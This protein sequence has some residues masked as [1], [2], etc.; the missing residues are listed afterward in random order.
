M[1][2]HY[3]PCV[4][5]SGILILIT[6]FY[7]DIMANLFAVLLIIVFI[8]LV[9]GLIKPSLFETKSN[10][11][12]SRLQ[13][14]IGGTVICLVLVVLIG[15]FAPEVPKSPD[16]PDGAVVVEADADTL[17]FVPADVVE[18]E[19]QVKSQA[20]PTVQ[21]ET[22]PPVKVEPNLGMTPEVF[23]K[24]YNALVDEYNLKSLSPLAKF[25]VQN[26]KMKDTFQVKMNE[27]TTLT[28]T[29]NKDGQLS[30]LTYIFG[31]GE[32][33]EMASMNLLASAAVASDVVNPKYKNESGGAWLD[34]MSTALDKINDENAE[35]TG[36]SFGDYRY[37][38]LASP[39]I[40]LW[41]GIEPKDK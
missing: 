38:A 10:P 8:T 26:G 9:V 27:F 12:M 33:A 17:S 34:L 35:S 25:N 18:E 40:G 20:V 30:G 11:K 6:F 14:A 3:A 2:H 13:I 31:G 15:V 36:K 16:V 4:K 41:M 23:R 7:G 39:H 37:Y 22:K 19:T 1:L 29:V 24:Q 32:G 5:I 28:G 21:T